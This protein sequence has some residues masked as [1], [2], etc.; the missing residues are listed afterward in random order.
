MELARYGR[1]AD[2]GNRFSGTKQP[3]DHF[4]RVPEMY[5][6]GRTGMIAASAADAAFRDNGWETGRWIHPNGFHRTDPDACI[7]P[8]AMI[9]DNI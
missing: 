5:R 1:I 4:N 2:G 9:V 6:A 3:S 7:A 8:D